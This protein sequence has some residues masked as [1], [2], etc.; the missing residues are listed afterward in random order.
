MPTQKK[1]HGMAQTEVAGTSEVA[2]TAP[3]GSLIR[4]VGVAGTDEQ[5]AFVKLGEEKSIRLKVLPALVEV[6][7]E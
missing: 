3:D 7:N 1:F 2:L 5:P 6:Q 4:V